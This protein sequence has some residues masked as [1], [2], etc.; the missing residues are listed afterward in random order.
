MQVFINTIKRNKFFVLINAVF[1][2]IYSLIS[3]VNYHTFRTYA[4]DLGYSTRILYD[5]AHFHFSY[6]EI[7]TNA[8]ENILSDHFD[9]LLMLFSPLY[10][11]FGNTT[12]LV[13]QIAAIHFGAFGFYK[14]AYNNTNNN[15]TASLVSLVFLSSFGVFS[16]IAFDYHSNLVGVCFV[17]W[18]FLFFQK[19]N[20]VNAVIFFALVI[21]AKENM[22]LWMFFVC[23]GFAFLYKPKKQKK[24]I[25]VFAAFSVLYFVL[26]IFFIMPSLSLNTSYHHFEFHV[27]GNNFK[28]LVLNA[29]KHPV[30]A[31]SL[32]FE[33]NLSDKNLNYVKIETWLF[34]LISGG[35]LFFYRP[36]FLWMLIPVMM[37][38]MY[39]DDCTKWGIAQHYNVEFAPLIALCL[40]EVFKGKTEKK[41]VLIASIAAIFSILVTI[42][43][44]DNTV[45]FADKAR[46]R[47][48]QTDHYISDFKTKDVYILLNKIPSDARVSA[49]GMFIPHLVNRKK[50]YLF[51]IVK[52]ATYILLSDDPHSFPLPTGEMLK[53]IDS[54]NSSPN[55]VHTPLNKHLYLFEITEKH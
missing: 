6:G 34:L 3:F 28:E 14:L 48:Y 38:K 24:A 43:L 50:A 30:K 51:P 4:L 5:Y 25:V 1:F 11:L 13:V 9:L 39:H 7:I 31:I 46:I 41:Q 45:A 23:T 20:Y 52:D 55:W 8:H 42:R 54:L 36:V 49:E 21:V 44:C 29:F 17:P 33:N 18:F 32:L 27:L 22:S 10:W 16:A 12:L 35:F 53:K 26:L 37:Q 15:R 2:I 19:E 47:F 40:I